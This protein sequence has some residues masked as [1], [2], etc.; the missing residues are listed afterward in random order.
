M[1]EITYISLTTIP[2]RFENIGK[3]LECLLSQKA[4]IFEIYLVIQK[5]YSRFPDWN[6]D[7]PQ[8]PKGIKLLRCEKDLGP[9]CKLFPTLHSIENIDSYVLYCDDDWEYQPMWAQTFIN[10]KLK[11]NSVIA[12]S[13]FKIERLGKKN[14]SIVQGFG[15]VLVQKR[16]FTAEDY[17][18]PS[19]FEFVGNKYPYQVIPFANYDTEEIDSY[20]EITF[21]DYDNPVVI[22]Y[23]G[24][25]QLRL[26]EGTG[27]R[28]FS[29]AD[30]HRIL[31]KEK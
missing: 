29:A 18:I 7:L 17:N 21:P 16:F 5:I 6:G 3:T 11:N 12:S 25:R 24:S 2:P 31:A 20:M 4:E 10:N 15:G 22:L 26:Y 13:T 23:D 27:D 19:F 28:S 14:G 1:N 8:V 30:L 9:A